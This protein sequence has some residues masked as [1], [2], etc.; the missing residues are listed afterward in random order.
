[1]HL[2]QI[3]CADGC[4]VCENGRKM[5]TVGRMGRGGGGRGGGEERKEAKYDP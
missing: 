3:K 1:M 4:A 2:R 5:K